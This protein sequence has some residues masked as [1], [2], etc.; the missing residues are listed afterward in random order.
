M[1]IIKA[2][3]VEHLTSVCIHWMWRPQNWERR[4]TDVHLLFLQPK[5][6][7]GIAHGERIAQCEHIKLVTERSLPVQID[8][9]E[10][11]LM[12]IL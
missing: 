7:M 1:L 9:G 2:V 11:W 4:L 12:E 5:L 10:K 6:Q 8:G 3:L